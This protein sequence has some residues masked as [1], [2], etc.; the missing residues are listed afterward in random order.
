M[1]LLEFIFRLTIAIM[2]GA[3][4]GFERQYRQRSAGL[5]TNTLVSAGA[6]IFIL[7]AAALTADSELADPSR[8]AGQ[9][10]T[11]IGFL[12]AGVIMKDGI[13]VKGLNTAANHLVLNS[14]GALAGAGMLIE[15]CISTAAIVAIHLLLRTLGTKLKKR[16]IRSEEVFLSVYHFEVRCKAEVHKANYDA[17]EE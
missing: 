3:A 5:R 1:E 12:G 8:V 16:P 10:V 15:A 13:T 4:I 2:L 14:I 9:I 17:V 6:A 7:L 11:G